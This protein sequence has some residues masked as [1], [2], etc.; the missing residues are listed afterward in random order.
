LRSQPHNNRRLYWEPLRYMTIDALL[1]RPR[2]GNCQMVAAEGFEPATAGRLPDQELMRLV[3]QDRLRT[4][5]PD[6]AQAPQTPQAA[7]ESPGA[8][9]NW[10]TRGL[11]SLEA[12]PSNAVLSS[13]LDVCL[14]RRPGLRH[15][16]FM[17]CDPP[18]DP[19][20]RPQQHAE[21]AAASAP[22]P[23]AV[24]TFCHDGGA[25]LEKGVSTDPRPL[26]RILLGEARP[27]YGP[28]SQL[29]R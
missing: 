2:T 20:S 22:H 23:D 27:D 6:S 11:Y 7:H 17:V 25:G 4:C 29:R 5:L 8:L 21:A 19:A 16:D 26:A 3:G 13:V 28:D 18:H 9:P 15:Y 24:E 14:R 1:G 12:H 10:L